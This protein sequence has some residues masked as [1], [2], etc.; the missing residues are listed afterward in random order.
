MGLP[1]LQ[2]TFNEQLRVFTISFLTC[3]V[4]RFSFKTESTSSPQK[5]GIGKG[6][7]KGGC[8]DSG[9]GGVV[10]IADDGGVT[11][12]DSG[13]VTVLESDVVGVTATNPDGIRLPLLQSLSASVAFSPL[14]AE[15][16]SLT[17]YKE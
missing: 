9:V 16:F 5:S 17:S 11:V 3:G 15:S 7:G 13:V 4:T 2:Y 1:L 12:V 14:H 10:T 8:L 6:E